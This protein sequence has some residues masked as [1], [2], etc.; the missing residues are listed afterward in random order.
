MFVKI[1]GVFH[2]VNLI[3]LIYGG[4]DHV[5]FYLSGNKERFEAPEFKTKEELVNYIE[6]EV[7]RKKFGNKLEKIVND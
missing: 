6:S 4:A 7:H 3:E 2:N 1:G 5:S